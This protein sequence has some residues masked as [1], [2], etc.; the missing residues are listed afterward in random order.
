MSYLKGAEKRLAEL[1]AEKE[2]AVSAATERA[3]ER[4]ESVKELLE[5]LTGNAVYKALP[6]T[7]VIRKTVEKILEAV[8]DESGGE[9]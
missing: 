7:S 2:D 8:A 1:E 3:R 4:L 9:E 6:A 5:T